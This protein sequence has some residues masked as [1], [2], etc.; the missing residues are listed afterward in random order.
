MTGNSGYGMR[1]CRALVLAC[2]LLAS[3]PG[4]AATPAADSPESRYRAFAAWCSP[5][6]LYLHIDRTCYNAG[7]TV[8]FKGWLENAAESAKLSLSNYI[9]VE[10]L[11]GKG[12]TL[13]RV[14]IK[15]SGDG[16]PGNIV[17]PENMATGNYTI[18]AYTLWQLNADPEYMFNERL[19]IVG[20]SKPGDG[21]VPVAE[22]TEISF[23]PEGGRYFAGCKSAIGF[24][25]TDKSGRYVDFKGKL[26]TAS[27][28]TVM[29][30]STRHNGMGVFEFYPYAGTAYF[31]ED[32]DG[33][34]YPLPAPATA[35]I[36][37]GVRFTRG[38]V[39]ASARGYGGGTVSLLIRDLVSLRPIANI[40]L[41]GR[42]R[43]FKMGTDLFRPGINHLLAVDSSGS[44]IAE[45]LFF[46][47][48]EDTP[49]CSFTPDNIRPAAR[50]LIHNTLTL[51]SPD[52]KPLNGSCSVSVVRGSLKDW[53]QAD[54][55]TSY[56]G[57]SSEIK[58][59]I[60][61]PFY[62]FDQSVPVQTRAAAMDLLM[63]IQGWRYYELEQIL[64]EESVAPV[65]KYKK[66]FWQSLHGRIQRR[67]SSKPPKNFVFSVIVPKFNSYQSVNVETGSAFL[68]DSL[69]FP[70]NTGFLINI[71]S[72]R[73]GATYIPKWDG[74]TFAPAYAYFPAPGRA[75]ALAEPSVPLQAA[76]ADTLK[77]AVVSAESGPTDMM[78][79]GRDLSSEIA[80][81]A[82][83]TLI[84]F[85]SARVAAF[86]YD[87]DIMYN[88]MT[89]RTTLSAE[90]DIE[91]DAEP[92][93]TTEEDGGV[94]L[95]VNGLEQPWWSYDMLR[96]EELSKIYVS[97]TPGIHGGS[98]G[99]VSITLKPGV[100]SGTAQRNPSLLYFVPLGHQ[101]PKFF[102]SPRYDLG[103]TGEYDWRSTIWWSPSVPVRE[104]KVDVLFCNTDQ[105]DYPYC[106]RIEGRTEEGKYF[107]H[108]CILD[109]KD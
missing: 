92:A 56:M 26:V 8:W 20:S 79:F 62:Y 67:V 101:E 66:E 36:T 73:F 105:M 60:D 70:E 97:S 72:S 28:Y 34:R 1:A 31:L 108:H 68:V 81:Y 100:A 12:H 17:L 65:I 52:G 71:G 43:T 48:D 49:H 42:N 51:K 29:P 32:S 61:E 44:I 40:S 57:L 109:F 102:S 24:K 93:V 80:G 85:L 9:Y 96:M 2:F 63:M 91:S 21:S 78:T 35:G 11:D 107:S 18:R 30:V 22:G 25:V 87:G 104:G 7:E 69:D 37:L 38:N 39:L 86:E 13:A 77:A 47:Y 54:G 50:A 5:E 16:F 94:K 83:Y 27:G 10:I 76:F 82:D 59:H 33:T 15:R 89:R 99:A 3:C 64:P 103:D 95:M 41:D 46:I 88:R 19:K 4:K 45:R 58:G 14:K 106:V 23:W 84:E 98:G 55:I 75:K 53:Q 74:D 90:T 6:K